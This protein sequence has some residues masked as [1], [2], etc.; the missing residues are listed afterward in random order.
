[1]SLIKELKDNIFDDDD[2]SF[3]ISK[4]NNIVKL[5]NAIVEIKCHIDNLIKLKIEKILKQYSYDYL[6]NCQHII[7]KYKIYI[8]KEMGELLLDGNMHYYI[9]FKNDDIDN[10][11]N[12]RYT[13]SLFLPILSISSNLTIKFLTY[14]PYQQLS[15]NFSLS[16]NEEDNTVIMNDT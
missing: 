13:I 2:L 16:Y 3:I 6:L 11:D 8:F 15:N 4:S 10:I 1:M 9:T 14:T 7:Y 12:R 5:K